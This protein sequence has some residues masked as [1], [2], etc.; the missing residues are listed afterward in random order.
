M[1]I[2]KIINEAW[3]N[4][5]KISPKS[6][7]EIL[8]SISETFDL[9]DKGKIRVAE[10][11]VDKWFTNQWIKKAIKLSFRTNPMDT[12]SGPYSSWYDK[13]HLLKGKTASWD[14]EDHEKAG[15]RFVPNGQVRK[16]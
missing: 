5:E 6:S 13:S 4:K 7:K 1:T 16:G 3:D 15:F 14:K 2:E 12:L 9:L 8:E 11:K 10:K